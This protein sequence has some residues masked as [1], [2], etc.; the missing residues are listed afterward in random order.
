MRPPDSPPTK[1]PIMV[2]IPCEAPMENVNGS[3]KTTAMAM[4]K[5]GMAPDRRP[6]TAPSAISARV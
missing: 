3:V 4:V 1:T 5:P 6:A 2:A